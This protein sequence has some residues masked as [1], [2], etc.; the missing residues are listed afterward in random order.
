MKQFITLSERF[1]LIIGF[2]H[3]AITTRAQTPDYF[4][5][6]PVWKIH[7]EQSGTLGPGCYE[8]WNYIYYI[9]GDST[10][11]AYTY[12]KLNKKGWWQEAG[13]CYTP[14]S[15]FDNT[16]ALLRQSGRRIYSYDPNYG[17]TLFVDYL[18]NIGDTL[19][20]C[21]IIEYASF[22]DASYVVEDVDS[23]SIAGNYHRRLHFSHQSG[24]QD[25]T[26][27]LLLEGI[28]TY[29]VNQWMV[30]SEIFYF[31]IVAAQPFEAT[32]EIECYSQNGTVL[33]GDTSCSIAGFDFNLGLELPEN[34][35]DMKVVRVLDMMGRETEDKPNT[36]LIHIF[37][38]G[39]TKKVFRAMH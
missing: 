12:K 27:Y 5:N 8:D 6:A 14:K 39:T 30:M 35:E 22:P 15:Y 23:V 13:M 28:G 16:S 31:P 20:N 18:L 26:G 10:I 19:K 4:N 2:V 24:P 33:Y 25:S 9:A 34:K 17:D 3:L 1:L 11:G 21:A 29:S 7:H 32:F 36:L 37:S 38:D